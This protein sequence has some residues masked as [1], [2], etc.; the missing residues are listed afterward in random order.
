MS[1]FKTIKKYYLH[2]SAKQRRWLIILV[3]SLL[4]TLLAISTIASYRYFKQQTD[5]PANPTTIKQAT[6]PTDDVP[7]L[8]ETD[9]LNILLLGY[10]GPGHQG[11]M[12][13]DL[14]QVLNVDLVKQR[15]NF[16]SIPRDLEIVTDSGHKQKINSLLSY[17]LNAGQD[18]PAASQSL[19]D[20]LTQVLGLN[21]DYTISVDFVGFQRLI[22]QTMGEIEVEVSQT[23]DDPWYPIEGKQ[24]DPCGY[25]AA[26]IAQLT[27]TLSGFELESQFACRYEQLY[28]EPGLHI[29]EG[30]DALAYV[31][32]RHSS[33]DFDRSRRQS[34]VLI[35]I[36]NKLFDLE[37]LKQIPYFFNQVSQHVTSNLDLASAEYLGP[38]LLNARD[39]TSHNVNLSTDNVLTSGQDSNG[40]ILLPKTGLNN[41]TGIQQFIQQQLDQE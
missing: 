2:L 41:W 36:R 3:S 35:A 22:G 6:N 29:M 19:Q 40:S 25:S 39:F 23:L 21:I 1:V 7:T 8:A 27:N 30:K 16:I 12:L 14:I 13:T 24:L 33:S 32:S 4:V 11:G 10:G 9:Q 17:Y 20:D 28:Y 37:V 26:E 38:L 34:E 5:Q 31:R 15:L 18:F